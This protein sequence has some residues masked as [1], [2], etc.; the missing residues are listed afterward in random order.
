MPTKEA[1]LWQ[2][3]HNEDFCLS[4]DIE[5]TPYRDWVVAA[6][7]YTALHLINA[8]FSATKGSPPKTHNERD[9]WVQKAPE[10]SKIWLDYQDLKKFRR[11]ASYEMRQFS[12][13]EVEKDILPLLNT[14]KED[15]RKL[16]PSISY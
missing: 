1:H 7:F 9:N 16:Q 14:I 13:Q 4:F 2:A 8:Y 11:D 3:R 5:K 6:I 12:A 15:L 10:L